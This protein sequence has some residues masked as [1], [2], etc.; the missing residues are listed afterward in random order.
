MTDDSN[1]TAP[2]HEGT[3]WYFVGTYAGEPVEISD[4]EYDRLEAKATEQGLTLDE[5]LNELESYLPL[6]RAS[7]RA[8]VMIQEHDVASVDGLPPSEEVEYHLKALQQARTHAPDEH[9]FDSD[10][11]MF[12]LAD[13]LI[14]ALSKLDTLLPKLRASHHGTNTESPDIDRLR[15]LFEAIN[16][17]PI[18][19]NTRRTPRA[20]F[21]D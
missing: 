15:P 12:E 10:S 17:L 14:Y 1:Q 8:I 4:A 13:A 2:S 21:R 11:Q 20:L 9:P 18:K 6:Q 7:S 16:G 3:D 19:K 5:Y